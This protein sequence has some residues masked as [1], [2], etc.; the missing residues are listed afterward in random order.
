VRPMTWITSAGV[1]SSLAASFSCLLILG[2]SS[3]H[4]FDSCDYF[5]D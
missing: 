1:S 5:F 2:C 3:F 4:L